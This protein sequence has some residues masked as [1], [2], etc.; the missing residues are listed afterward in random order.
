[1]T[2]LLES[3]RPVA[4]GPS[5]VP[6]CDGT[7]RPRLAVVGFGNALRGDRGAGLYVLEALDQ[8]GF[9]SHVALNHIVGD[10]RTLISCLYDADAAVIVQAAEACGR[11]GDV[12]ALDLPRFRTL[13]AMD[14]RVP[15]QPR[16]LA[17]ALTWIE[18]GHRLPRKLLILFIEPAPTCDGQGPGPSGPVRRGVR[19]AVD[20][21]ANFLER[22][23]A[24]R[25][26]GHVPDRLYAVPW[27]GI[28]F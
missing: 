3:S 4:P 27:L 17:E 5:V 6:A 19:R 1:M 23:G 16:A 18:V 26:A 2:R 24:D 8:A 7:T 9:G 21:A 13:A 25:P 20:L 22:N 12:H 15:S 11:P 14:H 28:R 10:Y